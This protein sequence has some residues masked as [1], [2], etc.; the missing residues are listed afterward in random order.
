MRVEIKHVPLTGCKVDI[1]LLE[2][3]NIGR[4]EK[5]G[6]GVETRYN[7]DELAEVGFGGNVRTYLAVQQAMV[8]VRQPMVS[9]ISQDCQIRYGATYR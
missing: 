2:C 5:H 1:D 7:P 3:R 9:L 6:N 4:N 8:W